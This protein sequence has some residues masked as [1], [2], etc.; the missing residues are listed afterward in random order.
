VPASEFNLLFR[1]QRVDQLRGVPL[2]APVINPAKD[3]DKYL[4]ATRVQAN[5]A[6]MFGVV[7][8]RDAAGLQQT[9]QTALASSGDYRTQQLRTGLMTWLKP[10]ESIETFR[11]DVP[12]SQFDSYA[13][14]SARIIAIGLG[15]TYEMLMH[16]F[17][18][19]S[20]S[21]A[22]TNL[23]TEHL[24][25]A[26][27]HRWQTRFFVRPVVSLWLSKRMASGLLDENPEAYD[28]IHFQ[29]PASVGIDPSQQ[30]EADKTLI[31]AGLDTFA[32][33]YGR[34]GKD[35]KHQL[36]KRA[37]E[38]AFIRKLADEFGVEPDEISSVLP[39]GVLGASARSQQPSVV[40]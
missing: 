19:M 24:L 4:S 21:A 22:K 16:D 11:P 39:P 20:Y 13:K 34:L 32:D 7:I 33:Y 12:A 28:R 3:L 26:G 10:G 18:G 37:K 30:A 5:I 29:T 6:A 9:K 40:V 25:I 15:T 8:K 17:S 35:E 27:W 1:R 14:F 2:L 31:A 38:A 23:L 36:R